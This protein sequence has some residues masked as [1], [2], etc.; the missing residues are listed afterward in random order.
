MFFFD[1]GSSAATTF[2]MAGIGQQSG[3]FDLACIQLEEGSVMTPFEELPI[4][5]SQQRVNRYY[6]KQPSINILGA[7]STVINLSVPIIYKASKRATPSVTISNVTYINTSSI[8]LN[9]SSNADYCN[10]NVVGTGGSVH[11]GHVS[12]TLTSDARL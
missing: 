9:A 5:V 8:S 12:F 3:T 2:N 10:V 11:N 7:C 6:E 1:C 4:E